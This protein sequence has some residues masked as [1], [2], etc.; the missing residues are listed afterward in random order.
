MALDHEKKDLRHPTE[1]T[2]RTL[3]YEV[4]GLLNGRPLTTVS[5]D[6]DDLR[7]LMPADY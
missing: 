4:S 3:L 1:D 6:P 5:E 7:P 2:L